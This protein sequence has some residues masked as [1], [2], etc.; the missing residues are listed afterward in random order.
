MKSNFYIKVLSV[1]IIVTILNFLL[2]LILDSTLNLSYYGWQVVSNFLI[3]I[4]L[5]YYTVHSNLKGAGL[6]LSVFII[7]YG[8]GNL[9]LI[10]EAII[11]NIV[12]INEVLNSVPEDLAMA[13][14]IALAIAYIFGKSK[15][16]TEKIECKS[17]SVLSWIWRIV[18]GDIL[19]LIVYIVA[20]LIL[21]NIYPELMEFYDEKLP[22]PPE[23]I[24]GTQ[25]IRG[26][27]FVGV[28]ILISMTVKLPLLKKAVLIGLIFSILG[29]IAPLILPN[30]EM[31]S[32]IRF[33]HIFE[34]GIS[35]FLYGLILGYL[36]EQKTKKKEIT[37]E[38]N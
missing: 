14:V 21:I 26:L 17:R 8:I 12:S 18:V 9:N 5:G 15:I 20:G 31:P 38:N 7:Y 10:V 1:T 22:P 11:F 25:L 29:G 28:A 27:L 2:N 36:L 35:N 33:G 34:V 16:K 13:I 24:F 6:A 19:Y 32:Y 23:L 4:L 37:A 30:E 3:F